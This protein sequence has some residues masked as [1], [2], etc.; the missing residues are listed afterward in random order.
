MAQLQKV[1]PDQSL[2]NIIQVF[3]PQC[4]GLIETAAQILGLKVEPTR[5]TTALKQWLV[6]RA[7]KYQW[8]KSYNE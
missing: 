7:E 5:R 8:M 2:P 4:L 6:E 3:R 1:A